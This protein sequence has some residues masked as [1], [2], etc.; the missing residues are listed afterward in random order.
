[1]VVGPGPSAGYSFNTE[2]IDAYD[3]SHPWKLEWLG[4][5]L[6]VFLR[7]PFE[8][9][10]GMTEACIDEINAEAVMKVE[11]IIFYPSTQLT[12][13]RGPV[14]AAK[15][16]VSSLDDFFN[17]IAEVFG[18]NWDSPTTITVDEK[19]I[20]DLQNE[21]VEIVKYVAVSSF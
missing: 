12:I 9:D 18:E 5:A 15:I 21:T 3:S 13:V 19:N 4:Y 14:K 6:P 20:E 11:E 8:Y 16:R 17:K 1:M 2:F 10:T 7:Y